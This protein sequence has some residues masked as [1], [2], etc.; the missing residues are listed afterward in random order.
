[1]SP[2]AGTGTGG[3]GSL[4]VDITTPVAVAGH[5]TTP[6]SCDATGRRYVESASGTLNGA[7][8]SQSVRVAGFDG[9]G[10]YPAVV[11][12]SVTAADAT[13]Q[14]VEAV[15]ASVEIT[16]TGGSVSFSASTAA[17][18]TLAGSIVWSC[19]D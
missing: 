15:P 13:P 2:P 18:R 5:V 11:A 12:V 16:S 10:T 19:S 3:P 8:V 7:T 6:V 17:G 1:V 9:P 4:T 14:S